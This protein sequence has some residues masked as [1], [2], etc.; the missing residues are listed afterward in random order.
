[1]RT[2]VS[3]S[4]VVTRALIAAGLGFLIGW[5]TVWWTGVLTG[6]AAL[7]FFLWA[8]SSGR[9]RVQAGGG[10]TPMRLDERT[11]A[12]RNRAARD[13][14]LVLMLG[15]AALVLTFVL[16]RPGDIPIE[17][18]MIMLGLGFLTYFVSDAL[19]RQDSREG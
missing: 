18:L 3:S 11:R 19:Q 8:P 6:V 4:Y 13:G 12:L 10:A 7:A 17:L 5:K 15:Q 1:M 9:Y 16:I 2:S 14:F